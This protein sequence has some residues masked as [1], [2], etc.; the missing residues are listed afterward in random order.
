MKTGGFSGAGGQVDGKGGAVGAGGDGKV[1]W[2]GGA[3]IGAVMG[4]G[5]RGERRFT[6]IEVRPGVVETPS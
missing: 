4:A 3:P 5:G 2:I 1:A 6:V